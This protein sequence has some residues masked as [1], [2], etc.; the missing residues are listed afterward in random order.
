MMNQPISL[1][2]SYAYDCGAQAPLFGQHIE[3]F[4]AQAHVSLR[5]KSDPGQSYS[6]LPN[7]WSG[8]KSAAEIETDEGIVI[9]KLVLRRLQGADGCWHYDIHRSNSTSG[10]AA[11]YHFRTR[12]DPWRST[13]GSWT[14]RSEQSDS[15]SFVGLEATGTTDRDC[16]S[17]T[18]SGKTVE[19]GRL[20]PGEKIVP[21]WAVSDWISSGAAEALISG[22]PAKVAVLENMSRLRN[23]ISFRP[24]GLWRQELPSIGS[25]IT[26]RGFMLSGQGLPPVYWWFAEDGR[27]LVV[28][29]TFQTYVLETASSTNPIAKAGL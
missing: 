10:E 23:G 22:E 27:L 19:I 13:E 28:S 24:L 15:G 7:F 12:D 17:I 11:A 18:T 29:S 25:E 26:M 3:R 4:L 9:G 6:I 16:I 21:F 2:W 14:I 20:E 5:Q 1:H 8:Y